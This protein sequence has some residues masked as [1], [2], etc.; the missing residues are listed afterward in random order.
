MSEVKRERLITVVLSM[1]SVGLFFL[2]IL[3]F[4]Q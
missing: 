1:V 4:I 3:P 2:V